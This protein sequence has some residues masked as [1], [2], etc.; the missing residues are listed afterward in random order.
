MSC[1]C[2]SKG[3]KFLEEN[4]ISA[5]DLKTSVNDEKGT[6]FHEKII[7]FITRTIGFLIGSVLITLIVIPFAI[8]TLFK[9]IYFDESVDV[10]GFLKQFSKKMFAKDPEPTEEVNIEEVNL[11]EINADDYEMV[12][13]E[14]ITDEVKQK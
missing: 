6:P 13:V 2:K 5:N 3:K 7:V 12:G 4:G 9:I 11:S 8:Y 10:S 1:N 14:D